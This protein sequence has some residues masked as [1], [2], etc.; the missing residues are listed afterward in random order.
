MP[1][2]HTTDVHNV[3][4]WLNSLHKTNSVLMTQTITKLSTEVPQNVFP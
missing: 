2:A 1:F 3:F 4:T